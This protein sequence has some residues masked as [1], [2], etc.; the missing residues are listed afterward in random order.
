MWLKS[1]NLK[2][3]MEGERL[4]VSGMVFQFLMAVIQNELANVSVRGIGRLNGDDWRRV[5]LRVLSSVGANLAR[6]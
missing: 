2:V 5:D 4:M 3:S 6:R 1:A